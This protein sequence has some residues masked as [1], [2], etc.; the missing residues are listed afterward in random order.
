[1]FSGLI[2]KVGRIERMPRG[3]GGARVA[4]SHDPWETPLEAGE[5]VAVQGVCLT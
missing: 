2:E 1:M 5:S 3:T 4:V